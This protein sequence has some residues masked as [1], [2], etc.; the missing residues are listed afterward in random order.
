MGGSQIYLQPNEIM[1]VESLFKSSALS[2]ANDAITALAEKV[3]ETES[4][5]VAMM[6]QRARDLGCINTN[7]VDPTGLHENDHYSTARDM[8]IIAQALIREGGQDILQ[9]TSY[10]EDYIRE[11]TDNKFF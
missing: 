5:F 9:Y 8:A 6:N 11:K 7:F 1:S 3:G 4:N 10:Y 2:S